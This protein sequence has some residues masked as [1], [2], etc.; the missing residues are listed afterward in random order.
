MFILLEFIGI[1][2]SHM[3]LCENGLPFQFNTIQEALIFAYENCVFDFQVVELKG[4]N[5]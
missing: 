3:F 2:E 5:A 4:G 1:G